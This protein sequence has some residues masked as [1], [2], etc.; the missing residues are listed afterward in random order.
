MSNG[1]EVVD[2]VVE[3]ISLIKDQYSIPNNLR[4][5]HTEKWETIL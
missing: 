4:S 5:C 1:L 3:D 2:N